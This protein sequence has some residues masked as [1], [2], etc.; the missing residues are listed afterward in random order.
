L[1]KKRAVITASAGLLGVLTTAMIGSPA[2]A[3]FTSTRGGDITRSE[4]L[5]RAQ[6]WVDHQ[7]GGYSQSAFSPGPADSYA[8]RRD[9]SGYVSMSWHATTSYTTRS[10]PDVS[11]AISKADLR[12]GDILDDYDNHTVVFKSWSNRSHT[13]INYYSFGSTPVKYRTNVLLNEG[14]IDSHPATAYKAYQY[15][16]IVADTP[17]QPDPPAPVQPKL[18]DVT[19]DGFSDLVTTKADGTMWLFSDNIGRDNGVP[20]NDVRQIGTGWGGYTQLIPLDATGDGYRDMVGVKADGTMWLFSNNFERDNGVPYGDVRQIGSGWNSYTKLIPADV[21]GD[22]YT[23]LVGVKA[24]GTMWLFSN[25]I[26]RDNGVPFSDVRQIGS[27]WNGYAKILGADVTGDGYTDLVGVKADGTMWLFSNNFERD[28]GVPYGDVRQIGSG[29]NSYAK[30]IPADVTGDG[31]TDL[32]GE[33]ADGT[34]W[35]FSNNIGRDNG[36]PFSDVRQ[37]GSGWDTYSNIF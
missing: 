35:L 34:M 16:H 10:L 11:Q 7:P 4:V 28:N 5:E 3:D 22:G 19:G 13:R 17:T 9:C 18:A 8:Y 23:D 1:N 31:Y 25:N 27:G 12:P 33:K 37:I 30:L 6:Y 36:V 14:N 24:D 20:Y 2:R 21:T 32:I 26:S 29:W 15:D